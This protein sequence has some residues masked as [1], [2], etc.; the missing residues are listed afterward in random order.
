MT[1]LLDAP[2]RPA[3]RTPRPA[4]GPA[5][6]GGRG[7]GAAGS[8]GNPLQ[9]AGRATVALLTSPKYG[10]VSVTAILF[11]AV[12]VIGGV[13]Y[14]GFFSGQ[15]FLLEPAAEDGPREPATGGGRPG[16]AGGD[17]RRGE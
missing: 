5:G 15:V 11:V 14:R 3:R 10:P 4:R 16:T 6:T 17:P 9:R 12:F 13:R 2:S 1:K 8:S 7:S